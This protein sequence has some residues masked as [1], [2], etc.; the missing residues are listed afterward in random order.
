M[1]MFLRFIARIAQIVVLKYNLQS[2][3]YQKKILIENQSHR[4]NYQKVKKS[5]V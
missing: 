1:N 5:C 4:E 3:Y 2:D